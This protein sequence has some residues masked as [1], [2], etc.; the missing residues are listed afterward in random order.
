MR[1]YKFSR[2][3][4]VLILLSL[5][6]LGCQNQEPRRSSGFVTQWALQPSLVYDTCHLIGILTGRPL[7]SKY[8]SEVYRDWSWN[9]PAPVKSALAQIDQTIGPNLPPGPRLSL[10]LAQIP[11]ADSLAGMIRFLQD[12]ELMRARLMVS[13]Y[14]TEQNWQQ[15]QALKPSVL[16]VL[17][18]L[19]ANRF[20]HYWRSKFLPELLARLPDMKQEL[21]AYDVAG[22]IER[23]L[24]NQRSAN[25]TLELYV[26]YLGQPHE[27]RL[28]RQARAVHMQLALPAVVRNFYREMLH[29]Y[30]DTLA[31][32]LLAPEFAQLTEDDFVQ[33]CLQKFAFRGAPL[34]FNAFCKK[35]LVLAAEL[36]LAERRQLLPQQRQAGSHY[37][38]QAAH[39][40]LRRQDDGAHALGV[41]IYSYLA[42]DLKPERISYADFVKDL[43]ASG[44]LRAGKIAGRY[45]D[46]FKGSVAP[47]AAD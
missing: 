40:Y 3:S 24:G 14:G 5:S 23:F 46:F 4:A 1:R 35:E 2:C 19:R 21:Q 22:D 37:T 6:F 47:A 27:V 44:K 13:D 43:F 45:H 34:E 9:L 8:F 42:A 29:P 41:I 39:E 38:T 16:Q 15:W 17:E 33:A 25:D 7:Y 20:E 31:D 12:D 28:R 11:P 18:Y 26:L 36:W 10:L 32:S 30:C